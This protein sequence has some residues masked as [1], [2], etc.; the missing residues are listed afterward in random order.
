MFAALE[1]Q[2]KLSKR[3]E[4]KSSERGHVINAPKCFK[5]LN[6]RG[7][8]KHILASFKAQ[9]W[10]KREKSI[11]EAKRRRKIFIGNR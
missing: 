5:V 4:M 10:M 3:K 7:V 11:Q 1:Q 8:Q 6:C 2:E 9:Q